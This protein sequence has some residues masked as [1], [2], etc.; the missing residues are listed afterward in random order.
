M[1]KKKKTNKIVTCICGHEA[2]ESNMIWTSIKNKMM[3]YCWNCSV[4]LHANTIARESN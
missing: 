1:P 3:L 2:F 4:K